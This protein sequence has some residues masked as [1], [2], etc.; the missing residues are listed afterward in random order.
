M[1]DCGRSLL[2]AL[3]SDNYGLT[4]AVKALDP[5]TAPPATIGANDQERGREL[6]FR[7]AKQRCLDLAPGIAHPRWLTPREDLLREF[8]STC[9]ERTREGPK[10]VRAVRIKGTGIGCLYVEPL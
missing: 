2:T 1:V 4:V 6:Y 8:V 10:E 7:A 3:S 9:T 5:A